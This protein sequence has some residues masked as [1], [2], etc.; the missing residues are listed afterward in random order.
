MRRPFLL[1]VAAA[2]A[3]AGFWFARTSNGPYSTAIELDLQP[4][5]SAADAVAISRSYLEA[6]S[7]AV[8][9]MDVEPHITSV[10]AVTARAARAADGC[11]PDQTSNQIVWITR[12][13]GDYLNVG[14]PWSPPM[15]QPD[16]DTLP[17]LTCGGPGTAGTIV[18]DDATGV[19]LGVYPDRAGYPH[20]TG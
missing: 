17:A 18:I 12:G 3:A 1:L 16:A 19:I 10:W 13:V 7:F 2:L 5:L 4:R 11:I 8:P 9:E 6:Q 15:R 20:P 14:F